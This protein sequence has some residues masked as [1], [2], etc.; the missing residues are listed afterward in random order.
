MSSAASRNEHWPRRACATACS[1][2]RCSS[3]WIW[4]TVAALR[5]RRSRGARVHGVRAG[6]P[7]AGA[8]AVRERGHRRLRPVRIAGR[9]VPSDRIRRARAQGGI[10]E[11]DDATEV[12]MKVVV[13]VLALLLA[14]P[15]MAPA[16]PLA[17]RE[18]LP[19]GIV[20]L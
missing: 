6:L 5:C 4:S 2:A 9:R 10:P 8:R 12:R 13:V 14:V 3:A 16:T 11:L 20:L 18:V 15:A 17:H 1:P 7:R 19:N